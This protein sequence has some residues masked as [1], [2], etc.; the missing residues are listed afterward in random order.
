M[1]RIG[2]RRVGISAES[3]LNA[4]NA[5]HS[6]RAAARKLNITSGTAWARLKE[7]GITPLGMS[8]SEAGRLGIKVRTLNKDCINYGH[9]DECL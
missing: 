9:D 6:I 8:R 2:R 1:N 4:Y 3:V 7:V 5:Y